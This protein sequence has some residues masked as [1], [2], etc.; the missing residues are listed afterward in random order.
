MNTLLEIWR[1]LDRKRRR[2][3]AWLQ[4]LAVIMALSTLGGV[5]AV[6]P[7]FAVL[8]DPDVVSKNHALAALYAAFDFGGPR[9][10]VVAL[11]LSFVALVLLS[12]LINL[13]GTL[14]MARFAAQVGNDFHVVLLDEYLHRDYLFHARRGGANLY[15]RVLNSVSRVAGGV[16]EGGMVAFANAV[17]IVLIVAAVMVLNPL[18]ATATVVWVGGSYAA[19]Y[20]STR[21]RLYRNGVIESRH[22]AERSRIANESLRA[23]KEV[24]LYRSQ[25]YF[26]GAFEAAC[27]AISRTA[28]QNHAIAQTPRYAMESV[29]VAGL[30]GAALYLGAAGGLGA[31]LAQLSFLGFAAYRLLPAIQALFA[32][33]VRVR[34]NSAAFEEIA[35]DLRLGLAARRLAARGPVDDSRW[36]GRPRGEIR[37]ERV[38]FQYSTERE[39]ALREV[40]LAIPAGAL[41]AIVG[42]NG[43]GKSTLVDVLLGLLPL[44]HG[45][46]RV[47]GERIGPEN[48]AAWQMQLAYVPQEIAIFDTTLAANI[49]LGVAPGA[50]DAARLQEALHGARLESLVAALPRGV[51]EL[52]GDRG[53]NLSVGQR[54]RIGIARALYRDASVLVMDE[55]TSALD[56]LTETE[57]LDLLLDL[58][59]TRTIVLVAHGRDTVRRCELIFELSQ[60]RLVGSGAYEELQRSS[61]QFRGLFGVRA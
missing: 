13:L 46:L 60:G 41:C 17:T 57:I 19:I 45:E 48:L 59:G 35:D 55:A 3:L 33:I 47:D 26:R 30:V 58:R 7:F 40:S 36:V 54:Q 61:A 39:F 43:S 25:G 2:Q 37:F 27:R 4:L 12:N 23:V 21:R 5:A 44:T 32:A 42:P 18:I 11:G 49:A 34:S 24:L 56:G 52:L 8:A 28:L 6:L 51:D 20:Y 50:V 38:W 9:H 14:A 22:V 31:W 16:L 15:N 10:F 53:Q 29:T 1:L